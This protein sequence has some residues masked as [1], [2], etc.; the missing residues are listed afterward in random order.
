MN[1]VLLQI[2][3]ARLIKIYDLVYYCCYFNGV[4]TSFLQWILRMAIHFSVEYSCM[5]HVFTLLPISSFIFHCFHQ[6][7]IV[8]K[9]ESLSAEYHPATITDFQSFLRM[10]KK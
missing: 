8:K 7:L 1:E 5:S 10:R 2:Q 4:N 6:S 3:S 9:P